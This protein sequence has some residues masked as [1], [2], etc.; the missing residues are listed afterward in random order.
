M[1]VIYSCQGYLIHEHVDPIEIRAVYS[2]ASCVKV[3]ERVAGKEKL[4]EA[5]D[6]STFRSVA[7]SLTF[8]DQVFS[9]S[10]P[11]YSA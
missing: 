8:V 9:S 4:W 11:A 7:F 10:S 6:D 5:H 2:A 3:S 1:R